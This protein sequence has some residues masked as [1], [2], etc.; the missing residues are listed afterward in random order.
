MIISYPQIWPFKI[1]T[2]IMSNIY[3]LNFL[4][5]GGM[6]LSSK[7]N[8]LPIG[9]ERKKGERERESSIVTSLQIPMGDP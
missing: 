2:P 6:E 7:K 9:K 3:P 8:G 1:K 5:K 4:K